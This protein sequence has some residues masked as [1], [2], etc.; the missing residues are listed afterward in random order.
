MFRL[1]AMPSASFS[2][3]TPIISKW[4]TTASPYAWTEGAMRGITTSVLRQPLAAVVRARAVAEVH[5]HPDGVEDAHARPA[6]PRRLRQ[7][8]G[9]VDAG[10]AGEDGQVQAAELWR[11][12]RGRSRVGYPRGV[13]TV[14]PWFAARRA[15][16][17]LAEL[18]R[19]SLDDRP[20]LL[21]ILGD[22]YTNEDRVRPFAPLAER[23]R[24]RLHVI[25]AAEWEP[26][27]RERQG[28]AALREL[29]VAP[30][31]RRRLLR[32]EGRG[33]VALL[34]RQKK[35]VALIDLFFEERAFVGLMGSRTRTRRGDAP[36]ARTR[37]P[38]GSTTCSSVS[39]RPPRRRRGRCSPASTTSHPRACASSAARAGRRCC[40]CSGTRR[41]DDPRR[42]RFELI[43][44]D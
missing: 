41:D 28:D 14:L 36:P 33:R 19:G 31:A 3:G 25:L 17:P 7:P 34:L 44:L 26:D 4:F 23:F 18:L 9:G 32:D 39:L 38:G 5:L 13:Y 43:E 1:A 6:Q 30:E 12:L 40:A 10:L 20:T 2:A 24:G 22:K 42:D 21:A 29:G 27:E 15:R 35:P 16:K 8:A 37:S 11:A